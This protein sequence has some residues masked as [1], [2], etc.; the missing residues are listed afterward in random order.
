MNNIT[1]NE[2]EIYLSQSV[3]HNILH[4]SILYE[5][6]K[7]LIDWFIRSYIEVTAYLN[8]I[9]PYY[10]SKQTR[11]SE[12]K[13]VITPH[14][15]E[16]ILIEVLISVIRGKERQTIQQCIGYLQ[17]FMPHDDLF[18]RVKTA[19]E[20]LAVCSDSRKGKIIGL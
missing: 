20:L 10:Q 8:P 5:M 4:K 7:S 1:Q 6:D 2:L 19:G 15:L 14:K 11:I 9:E 13:T 18:D 12:F 3:I 17:N 16:K